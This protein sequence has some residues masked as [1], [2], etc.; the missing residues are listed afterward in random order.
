[1]GVNSVWTLKLAVQTHEEG[2][3]W[4]ADCPALDI[5]SQGSDPKD[6]IEMLKEALQLVMEHCL[7]KNT[8]MEFLEERGV[9]P[10]RHSVGPGR[11]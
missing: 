11:S 5:A 9:A 4:V 2:E 8:W 3:V 7:Q 1:M 10:T 6:A